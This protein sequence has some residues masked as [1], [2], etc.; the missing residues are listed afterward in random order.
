MG[1]L[2]TCFRNCCVDLNIFKSHM[3]YMNTTE[4]IFKSLIIL[5]IQ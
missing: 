5:I 3:Y 2:Y 4:K 1:S